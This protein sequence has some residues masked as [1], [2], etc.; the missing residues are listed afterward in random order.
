ME[1]IYKTCGFVKVDDNTVWYRYSSTKFC[2]CRMNERVLSKLNYVSNW[3][4]TDMTF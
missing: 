2:L 1:Y 3:A 4:K